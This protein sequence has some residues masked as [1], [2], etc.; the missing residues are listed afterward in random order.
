[1]DFKYLFFSTQGRINRQPY[2]IASVILIVIN[3]IVGI[4]VESTGLQV[5]NIV[6]LI[7]IWPSVMVGIK[8]CHD[9]DRSG[10]FVLL[11]A[12]PFVNI[13]VLIDLGFL[14]GTEGSNRFG[15]NPIAISGP[16]STAG[17]DA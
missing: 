9:R 17:G 10:W 15:D 7:L 5:L 4:A 6:S 16:P 13:W 14:A 3:M 8:R 11:G 1:M 2:W 12:I